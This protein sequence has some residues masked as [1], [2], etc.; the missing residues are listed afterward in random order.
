M[1]GETT[2]SCSCTTLLTSRANSPSP[3]DSKGTTT[4]ST[5]SPPSTASHKRASTGSPSMHTD[6]AGIASEV[7]ITCSNAA[8]SSAALEPATF[9]ALN[10][11]SS[12][13]QGAPPAK[14]AFG[15]ASHDMGLR[16]GSRLRPKKGC[17][18]E[19][20]SDQEVVGSRHCEP[21]YW[22]ELSECPRRGDKRQ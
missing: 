21:E 12:G 7:S 6:I 2:P 5:C 22:E 17:Q 14:P 15:V 10:S 1:I 16:E 19:D 4:S 3:L 11:F 8:S 9:R 20:T 18:P 13:S